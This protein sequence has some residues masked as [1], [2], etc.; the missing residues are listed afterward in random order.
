MTL[1]RKYPRKMY[2]T[3]GQFLFD[4]KTAGPRAEDGFLRKPE[5]LALFGRKNTE[6][7]CL[8]VKGLR[9]KAYSYALFRS[10][11]YMVEK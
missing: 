8:C 1:W 11:A 7:L 5:G 9:L 3:C 4:E 2:G 10:L 6:Y